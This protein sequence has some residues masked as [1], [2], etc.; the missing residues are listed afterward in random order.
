MAKRRGLSV[1]PT[2]AKAA[3]GRAGSRPQPPQAGAP[4]ARLDADRPAADHRAADRRLTRNTVAQT[5]SCFCLT[6][7]RRR[8]T[9]EFSP[10]ALL[11]EPRQH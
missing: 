6:E 4:S 11:A 5:P 1:A 2:A 9:G 10:P 7:K 8:G 3:A